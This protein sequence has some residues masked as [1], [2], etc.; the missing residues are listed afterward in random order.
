[1]APSGALPVV[2]LRHPVH[3]RPARQVFQQAVAVH[4]GLEVFQHRAQA[5]GAG[6]HERRIVVPVRIVGEHQRP[7]HREGRRVLRQ[8]GGETLVDEAPVAARE[9]EQLDGAL[10]QPVVAGHHAGGQQFQTRVAVV[11]ELLVEGAVHIGLMRAHLDAADGKLDDAG[12]L[13]VAAVEAALVLVGIAVLV[14]RQA[15]QHQRL[16]GRLHAEQAPAARPPPERREF[17]VRAALGQERVGHAAEGLADEFAAV[18][19]G[20]R[21]RQVERL[22]PTPGQ[23]RPAP[24]ETSHNG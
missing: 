2:P 13:V 15:V 10:D 3:E 23:L 18:A 1:M 21:I 11:H 17:L 8:I 12:Q 4:V 5:D 20:L 6:P 16:G 14:E 9:V 24:P 22:G 7:D 19:F